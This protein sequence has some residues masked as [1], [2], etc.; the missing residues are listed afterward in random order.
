MPTKF[1]IPTEKR[2]EAFPQ[3]LN[4]TGEPFTK[5]PLYFCIDL[6]DVLQQ[7]ERQKI[8]QN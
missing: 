1:T 3:S 6:Q 5:T 4:L 8:T 2:N 7:R